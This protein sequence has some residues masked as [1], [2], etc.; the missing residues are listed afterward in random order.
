MKKIVI[1]IGVMALLL[2]SFLFIPKTTTN[3]DLTIYLPDDSGTKQ[4]LEIIKNEFSEE[5]AIQILV[6]DVTSQN[7]IT[8]MNSIESVSL[9][10]QVIWLDDYVDLSIVPIEFIDAQTLSPFYQDGDALFTIIFDADAY[11]TA[12][13]TSINSIKVLL[14]DY[15]LH[16]RGDVLSNIQARTVASGEVTKILYLI[17]PI[18]III[19]LL[20]SHAWVEPLLVLIVL[21]IAVLFNIF[22]NGLL[23]NVS[24]IT[25]TMAL[26]LQLALSIDY[27]LFMIHRFYEERK[28][29]NAHDASILARN[30]A[31]KSITASALTTIAG[32]TALFFMK[33]QIGLDIGLVLSK[34]IIFS[35][36]STMIL[37][38]TLLYWFDPLI[39]KTKHGML[40][41]SFA[42]F[43][44][45]QYK[46]RYVLIFILVAAIGLGAYF[47]SQTTYIYG[48]S[49]VGGSVSTL[50]LDKNLIRERFGYNNQLVILFPN[51]TVTQ[52]VDLAQALLAHPQ[53][54]HVEALVTNVDPNIPRA[55]LPPEVV[56]QFVGTNYSKMII[57][58][59]LYEENDALYQFVEDLN[60]LVN[61]EYDEYYIVGNASALS[62][63]RTSIL[64]QNLLITLLTIIA[65]GVIV[66]IIF[67]SFTIPILLVGI[68]QGAV[69]INLSIL[70]FMGTEVIY[71][72]YLVV[73]SIQLGATIDYA[74]LLT[75]RYLDER[76]MLPKKE[77]MLE[78]YSKSSISILISGAILTIAGFTEG[79]FSNID[80]VT[81]IG[82]LLGKGAMISSLMIFIFLPT[83]LVLLDKIIVK[84]PKK[85]KN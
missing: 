67:K 17:I 36:L 85:I 10:K 57:T 28:T 60:D 11:D 79:I 33:Y 59:S 32:F 48:S 53:I 24:F 74:V 71:I 54:T 41:P 39:Q 45:L 49:T 83:A 14:S 30:H 73:M 25:Q 63:I 84:Q 43:F 47:Q 29:N 26:A 21:G 23:S 50:S 51:E 77:A 65:V 31:F 37:L 5:S 16:L 69:W 75:N 34:G 8:L 4:G 44:K 58:T 19:L 3:Y 6:M 82:L 46:L 70:Y 20:A 40:I 15:E 12:L 38:P 22:T 52:E 68:I 1:F 64:D 62:D 80:A 56:N 9:V 61:T 42:K 27:A 66:G 78:A 18:I 7:L 81:D 76:K 55:F 13:E 2:A 72:G 35:Y